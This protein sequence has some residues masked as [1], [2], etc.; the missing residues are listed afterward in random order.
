MIKKCGK[1][2]YLLLF[3][4]FHLVGCIK[5][6]TKVDLFKKK[7][8]VPVVNVPV[9]PVVP[10][11]DPSL[12]I[13]SIEQAVSET[14]GSCSF[15]LAKDPT[16]LAGFEFRIQSSEE[17]DISTLVLADFTNLGTGGSGSLSWT[18]SHCGDNKNFKL[19]VDALSGEGT[20]IPHLNANVVETL[21]GKG[22]NA[23][24]SI[25]G[26]ITYDTVRPT[27][28]MGQ[29]ASQADPTGGVPVRFSVQFS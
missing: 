20:I 16:N 29:H 2:I 10:V 24:L 22:N 25:D 8:A 23:S 6:E 4:M 15:S 1:Y 11:V 12:A 3:V 21:A 18:L 19:K 26:S 27:L 17:L 13:L 5:S 28:T 14:V 7:L 9:A